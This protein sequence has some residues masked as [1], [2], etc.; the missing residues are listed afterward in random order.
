MLRLSQLG[1]RRRGWELPRTRNWPPVVRTFAAYFWWSSVKINNN[2][3]I[4]PKTKAVC[5]RVSRLQRKVLPLSTWSWN[6]FS[7]CDGIVDILASI[8]MT[9]K[10]FK[11]VMMTYKKYLLKSIVTSSVKAHIL[12]GDIKSTPILRFSSRYETVISIIIVI[13]VV[14]F[15]LC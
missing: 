5:Q 7:W 15:D 9:L 4:L 8:T 14:W 13:L 12:R 6:C 10:G 11:S 2:D 1:T 3:I